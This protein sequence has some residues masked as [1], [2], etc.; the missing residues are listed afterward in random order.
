MGLL[1]SHRPWPAS[2][3]S[4]LRT[5]PSSPL[6]PLPVSCGIREAHALSA[7]SLGAR[8]SSGKSI[9]AT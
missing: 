3:A 4:E 7:P 9:S 1:V 2:P 6:T 8:F 5:P